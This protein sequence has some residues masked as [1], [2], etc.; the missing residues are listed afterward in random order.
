MEY[1]NKFGI[2]AD[3]RKQVETRAI[4]GKLGVL[5]KANGSAYVEQGKT[6]VLIGIYGPQEVYELR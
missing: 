2:R 3:E 6:K 4:V 5:K 1:P